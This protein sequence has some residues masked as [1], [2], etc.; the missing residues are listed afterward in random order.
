MRVVWCSLDLEHMREDRMDPNLL[1]AFY[2][3]A[4]GGLRP[5]REMHDNELDI[6]SEPIVL[7]GHVEPR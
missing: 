6:P 4:R 1:K 7:G 5:K 2:D 3:Q